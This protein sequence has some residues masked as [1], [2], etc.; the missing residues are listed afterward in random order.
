MV[1][2]TL[3]RAGLRE[4]GLLSGYLWSSSYGKPEDP[5]RN[6]GSNSRA[7]LESKNEPMPAVQLEFRVARKSDP[8]SR[9]GSG[10]GPLQKGFSGSSLNPKDH[11]QL[12]GRRTYGGNE[13]G[14]AG[15]MPARAPK[16]Y[17]AVV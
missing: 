7:S 2:S 14:D 12:T 10:L 15:S 3:G 13:I 17:G 16:R 8:G 5:Q 6:E 4:L 1:D 9:S 11:Y